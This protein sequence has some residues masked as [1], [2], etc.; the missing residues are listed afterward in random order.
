MSPSPTNVDKY[1]VFSSIKLPR[2]SLHSLKSTSL[3]MNTFTKIQECTNNK[4]TTDS[5][6]KMAYQQQQQNGSGGGATIGSTNGCVQNGA[7]AI[8]D[9]LAALRKLYDE[10]AEHSDDSEKAD[11]EVRSYMS[12]GGDDSDVV[13]DTEDDVSSVVSGSWSK[14]RAFRN[15]K[16]H[17]HNIHTD[18]SR[19]KESEMFRNIINRHTYT[20]KGIYPS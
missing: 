8:P 12:A 2:A 11:E 5:N 20:K 16:Q 7:T 4:V 14:M 6:N 15:I 10:A 13:R 1:P 9:Q 17:L 3:I 19:Q 18:T